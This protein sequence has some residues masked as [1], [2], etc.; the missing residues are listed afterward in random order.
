MEHDGEAKPLRLLV[1]RVDALVVSVEAFHG[2]KALDALEPQAFHRMPHPL[3]GI[4]PGGVHPK[5]ADE[6]VGK[7]V[8]RLGNRLFIVQDAGEEDSQRHAVPVQ[9]LDPAVSQLHGVR[10]RD[11]PSRALPQAPG[12]LLRQV[13]PAAS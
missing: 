2:G 7:L 11:V 6:P 3:G 5:E 4:G 1:D 10:G 8:H 13:A 9:F 12:I